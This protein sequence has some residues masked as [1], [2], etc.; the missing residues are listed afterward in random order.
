[1]PLP[2]CICRNMPGKRRILRR[3]QELKKD[4]S[5]G[6]R[7]MPAEKNGAENFCLASEVCRQE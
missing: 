6:I 1:M 2:N 3:G 5:T 4:N 7:E